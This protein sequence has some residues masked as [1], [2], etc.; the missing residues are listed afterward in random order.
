MWL[1]WVLTLWLPPGYLAFLLLCFLICKRWCLLYLLTGLLW[2]LRELFHEKCLEHYIIWH[3]PKAFLKVDPL[4]PVVLT[5][6]MMLCVSPE[7]GTWQGRVG[8]SSLALST[9]PRPHPGTTFSTTFPV[10]WLS[11]SQHVWMCPKALVVLPQFPCFNSAMGLP[12]LY[13]RNITSIQ[14]S[15]PF[16]LL[17]RFYLFYLLELELYSQVFLLTTL[18]IPDFIFWYIVGE[19]V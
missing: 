5:L 10:S 1:H 6:C 17:L 18:T 4:G 3:L 9:L 13:C 11:S 8:N 15:I 12:R 2:I 14:I 19:K 16:D 7:R